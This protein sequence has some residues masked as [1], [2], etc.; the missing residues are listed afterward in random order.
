VAY[1]PPLSLT[2]PT[3]T[4]QL[5]NQVTTA[6]EQIA[7]FALRSQP[8][9]EMIADVRS[10]AQSHNAA[11]VQFTFYPNMAQVT[12]TLTEATD[13]T[14]VA[15]SDSVI[16]VTLAEYGSSV[17][18]TALIRGTSFLNVDADAAN[19]IGYNMVD[20]LDKVVSDVVMAGTNVLYST[21]SGA[22]PTSRVTVADGNTFDANI[23]R[24]AVA[25]LRGASA[26]GWENGNYM[27]I[28]HPDVSFDF[29]ALTAVTD[30][31]QYQLYQEGAPIRAGSIGTFNGINYI[32][33]PRAPILDDA[34]ATST[35]NVYQTIVA[36][37]Q[38]LAKAYSRAPGFGE[39]PSIVFGPVTDT[40]RRFNPVG[41]YHLAGWGIFR[42]AC[43]RRIES[44]SS[45]G[46][47]T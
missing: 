4:G 30:V 9:Y 1:T 29:R 21:G 33:N 14:P 16:T 19:I 3:G 43:L 10:T 34:G 7:Y 13:V 20:S 12:G 32:E 2:N 42:Q 11:T 5:T 40:L 25:E 37:R 27:A 6:F 35:T 8:L 46:D 45:I 22:L 15:L 36:G 18:T 26:P 38:A 23:G 47:N 17:I 28:L 39:Q 31:I 44:S 24:Q 41:W